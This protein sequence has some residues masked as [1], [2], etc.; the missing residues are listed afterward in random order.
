MGDLATIQEGNKFSEETKAK[1]DV[2]LHQH[3]DEM[4]EFEYSNSEKNNE[5][6][7]KNHQTRPTGS[8]AL[9]EANAIN[10]ND[11]KN[12]RSKRGRGNPHG[13]VVVVAIMVTTVFLTKTILTTVV[14]IMA[15]VVVK[16]ITLTMLH[17]LIIS[18]NKIMKLVPPKTPKDPVSGVEVQ[19]IGQKLVTHLHIYVSFTK[20]L[21][22]EK[23]KKAI[24]IRINTNTAR[25]RLKAKVRDKKVYIP[26]LVSVVCISISLEWFSLLDASSQ[27][28]LQRIIAS[29]HQ[30]FSMTDLGSLN[31]FLGIS[32][33]RDSSGMFLLERTILFSSSTKN[34]VAYSDAD[35]AGC[36][37]TRRSTS[38][39]EAEYRGVA[40]LLLRRVG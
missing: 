26:K 18:I 8:L 13:V 6:L 38:G 16:E 9:P 25:I 7:M 23:R 32:V 40:K 15:V 11:N 33:T 31:Y 27:P 34:L 2:F 17:K 4:L 30:E 21:V 14:V 5:L 29:L 36:P 1:A 28:L 35:W 12:S 22:K 39:V 19:I 10:N 37:K 24:R 20:H 3:I